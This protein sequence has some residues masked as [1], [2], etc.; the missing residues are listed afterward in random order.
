MRIT[1]TQDPFARY[2]AAKSAVAQA[3]QELAEAKKGVINALNEQ[4]LKS[5]TRVANGLRR[6]YTVSHKTTV[7]IDEEG[8]HVHLGDRKFAKYAPRKLDRKLLERAVEVGEL[9]PQFVA[10]FIKTTQG[11]PYIVYTETL[12]E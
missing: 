3:E 5:T 10:P 2:A 7:H 8:L 11:D 1:T 9:D 4:Q 12:D 6:T